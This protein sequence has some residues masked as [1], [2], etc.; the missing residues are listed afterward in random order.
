MRA[1]EYDLVGLLIFLKENI[2]WIDY[3]ENFC[4]FLLSL[5]RHTHEI[6]KDTFWFV[7]F[8]EN[9]TKR[10]LEHSNCDRRFLYLVMDL[11]TY[12]H[13]L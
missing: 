11:L 3:T 4:K 2:L 6:C 12:L 8:E 1:S 5:K 10:F 7:F 9:K 13:D